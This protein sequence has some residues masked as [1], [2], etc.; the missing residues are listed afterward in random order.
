[1]TLKPWQKKG[2]GGKTM[3][4]E[5]LIWA[6]TLLMILKEA[7]SGLVKF[8]CLKMAFIEVLKKYPTADPKYAEHQRWLGRSLGRLKLMSFDARP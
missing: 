6:S 4:S 8:M 5:L 2:L 1:M 3:M 7:P